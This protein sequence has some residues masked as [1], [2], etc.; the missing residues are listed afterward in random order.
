MDAEYRKLDCISDLFSCNLW[1]TTTCYSTLFSIRAEVRINCS[2][3]YTDYIYRSF[4]VVH[5]FQ[6]EVY[7]QVSPI[8]AGVFSKQRKFNLF[9]DSESSTKKVKFLVNF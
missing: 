9:S 7:S 2:K 3:V 1:G 4:F 6:I 8:M 5:H